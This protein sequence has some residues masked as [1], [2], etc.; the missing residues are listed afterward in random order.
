MSAFGG[1]KANRFYR[2]HYSHVLMGLMILFF[3]TLSSTS[4]LIYQYLN[5]P[6]PIFYAKDPAGQTILLTPYTDPNLLAPTIITWASKAATTAYTF[7]F[8][9][10]KTQIAAAKPY[11]TDNGWHDYLQSVNKLI[12]TIVQNQLFV[13]SVVSGTPVIANEGNLPQQ[14]YT[15]RLQIPFLVTYQSAN[16]VTQKKYLVLL[17]I[18]RVPTGENVKGIGVNQFVMV[19]Q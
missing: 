18:V 2:N 9:N 6:L 3:L 4:Y 13:S 12:Q 14:G 10:Y 17:T 5:R 19:G 7:D 11:F 1:E 16:A 8:V 15:W